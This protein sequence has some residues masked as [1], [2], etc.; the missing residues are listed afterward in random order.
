MYHLELFKM[1]Q[2]YTSRMNLEMFLVENELQS[3]MPM[4]RSVLEKNDENCLK[5]EFGLN[6]CSRMLYAL[7]L[8][9]N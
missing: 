8:S 1:I 5:K 4:K 2:F 7:N 9:N 3:S 6:K